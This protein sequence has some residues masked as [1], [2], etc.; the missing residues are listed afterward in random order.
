MELNLNDISYLIGIVLSLA[1]EHIPQLKAL[2]DKYT[3]KQRFFGQ[4]LAVVLVVVVINW[5]SC[6]NL[7]IYECL[8]WSVLI[9]AVV[10]WGIGQVV[11]WGKKDII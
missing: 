9:D 8:D 6:Y 7:A 10:A 5:L 1:S 3:P 4:L 2:L 11:H